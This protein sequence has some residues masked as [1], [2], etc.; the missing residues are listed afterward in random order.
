MNHTDTLPGSWDQ[1]RKRVR[2]VLPASYAAAAD[3][4]TH[5]AGGSETGAA[6]RR[7]LDAFGGIGFKQK[8]IH[9]VRREEVDL[10]LELFDRRWDAPIAIAPM[11]GVIASVCEN[12]FLEMAAAAKACAVGAGIGY[13]AAPEMHG[14]MAA[15]GGAVFRIVKPLKDLGKLA[16]ALADAQKAGCCAVGIDIDSIAGL[17]SGD[18]ALYDELCAPICLADLKELRRA[19]QIPFILKGVLGPADAEAALLAGADAIVVSTHSGSAMDCTPSSLEALPEI[20]RVVDKRINVL[21]DSGIRRGSDIIK[22]LALGADAVLIGRLA[23]W[24]L[25]IGKAEGLRRIVHLLREEMRRT[26]LLLGAG[27]LSELNADMLV[28]LNDIG[29]RILCESP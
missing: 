24:G 21:F 13:P 11:S 6:W 29:D 16:A 17:R 8:T 10:S 3:N 15:L 14:R 1:I 26:M 4:W 25:A 5:V 22:A 9:G 18:H 19:V 12:A 28:A 20:V 23:L 27:K 2:E 7:T